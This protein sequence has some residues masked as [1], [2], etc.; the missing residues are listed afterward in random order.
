MKKFFVVIAVILLNMCFALADEQPVLK[1]NGAK[2]QLMYSVKNKEHNG[3]LNEYFKLG[4]DYNN[5]TELVAVHHFP[6]AYSPLDQAEAFR[7]Y[8]GSIN[9][10]SALVEDEKNNSA[11]IDFI[12]IDGDK[13]PIILEFNVFKYA[14]SPECGTIALQYAKRYVVSNGLEVDGIKKEFAKTRNSALKKVEK[15]E[16]PAIV[17]EDIDKLK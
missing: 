3:Y 7:E 9:C 14:K 2:Y 10:P 12:L 5:W 4:E 16:I 6:N 1:F 11:I 15:Y 8:L 13:L 17:K